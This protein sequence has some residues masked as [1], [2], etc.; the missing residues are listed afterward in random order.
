MKKPWV[1]HAAIRVGDLEWYVAFL[2]NALGL[3]ITEVQGANPDR[4]DQVWIGGFQLTRDDA[5]VPRPFT[6]ERMWHIGVDV[7]DLDETL[8]RALTD[9]RVTPFSDDPAQKYWLT[10]PDGL[11]I[12]LVNR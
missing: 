3:K 2:Q 5:Y 12:E 7:A 6:Q 10:L 8:A 11:V 4:P 1:D 9:S